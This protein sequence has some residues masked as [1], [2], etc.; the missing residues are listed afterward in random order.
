M[1]LYTLLALA[2]IA[3]PASSQ[4]T[5]E[6]ISHGKPR[7]VPSAT[8][9]T[10]TVSR[11]LTEPLVDT[12]AR[13]GLVWVRGRDFRASFGAGG[14]SFYPVLGSDAP[15][16]LPVHFA[17][18][19]VRIGKSA[20]PTLATP[21]EALGQV[22]TIDHGSMRE[23]HHLGLDA[24]E[25]TFVFD[26]LPS[27]GDLEVD[28]RVTTELE[29]HSNGRGD[30][31]FVDPELG[32]VSYGAAFVLDAA[33]RR[34]PIAREWHGQGIRLTVPASFL[35]TAT[36]PVKIDPPI[37]ASF[38]QSSSSGGGPIDATWGGVSDKLCVVWAES[39]DCF[40]T[41]VA[42]GVPGP[43]VPVD[44]SSDRWGS[45]RVA[46]TTSNDRFAILAVVQDPS[47]LN[48][49][50]VQGRLLSGGS[51]QQGPALSLVAFDS[52]PIVSMDVG[53]CKDPSGAGDEFMFA[54]IRGNE[55]FGN[56]L[57][58]R[59]LDQDGFFGSAVATTV[60]ATRKN[61]VSIS[62]SCGD[63]A[64][65]VDQHT[66]TWVGDATVEGIGNI[67][68][69]RLDRSNDP[70]LHGSPRLVDGSNL[71]TN[72]S[73]TSLFDDTLAG[74]SGRPSVI[75]YNRL[76]FLG[77]GQFLPS[78]NLSVVTNTSSSFP[79]SMTVN[80]EDLDGSLRQSAPSIATDGSSFAVTYAEE[81][82]NPAVRSDDDVYYAAGSIYIGESGPFVALSERHQNLDFSAQDSGGQTM[83]SIWG[84][85]VNITGDERSDN[86][87]TVW[88]NASQSTGSDILGSEIELPTDA[89]SQTRAVGE[90]FCSANANGGTTPFK[91]ENTGW[92]W[93]EGRQTLAAPKTAFAVDVTPNAFGYLITGA[94]SQI[95][96]NPAGS[97]GKLCIAASGRYISSIQTS[98][99]AGTFETIIDPLMLPQPTG[100]TAAM[101]G[102]S[103]VF[104]YWHRDTLGG[105]P[106][107][108]FTNACSVR[109][110][111]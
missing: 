69:Q 84:G 81:Y 77:P 46:Y 11:L 9:P 43:V 5:T 107:S 66:L 65:G 63:P 106:T 108:N 59:T 48:G 40:A 36:F 110:R 50:A 101:P 96:N 42:N 53:G 33:G 8:E 23:V 72:P 76:V 27:G 1:T 7:P 89:I 71:C 37:S 92:M 83:C 99:L 24:I 49:E 64:M 73:V 6:L 78:V 4:T 70:S 10:F 47:G 103:W 3:T 14:F 93:I 38:I 87:F 86:F 111:N 109:F 56:Q 28:L 74:A 90:Q 41:L 21:A 68:A 91:A 45:P 57:R 30:L 15:R 80:M 44:I 79:W 19:S 54:W 100:F 97:A 13:D 51:G 95:V 22:I 105:L 29:V 94:F 62:E 85:E 52:E 67:Y 26:E 20:I 58:Y 39:S 32:H 102:E 16:E 34:A 88:R 12:G 31:R 75:A 2:T 18:S 25:Q 98:G 55:A 60:D 61:S 82:W 17:V 104:Q 35:E